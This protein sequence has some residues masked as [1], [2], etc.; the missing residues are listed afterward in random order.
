MQKLSLN[1]FLLCILFVSSS[2][3]SVTRYSHRAQLHIIHLT[4]S[5]WSDTLL[6]EHLKE[7]QQVY[8]QCGLELTMG[9][10]KKVTTETDEIYFDLEG[11]T[12]GEAPHAN[13][14]L[15]F[16]AQHAKKN[17]LSLFLFQSFDPEYGHISATAMPKVRITQPDQR[18]AENT[19]WLSYRAEQLRQPFTPGP[20]NGYSILAHE[21]GHVLLNAGHFETIGTFNLMHEV[22]SFLNGRL[23]LEQ[24]QKIQASPLVKKIVNPRK[25]ACDVSKFP[26]IGDLFFLNQAVNLSQCGLLN[27]IADYLTRSQDEISDLLPAHS[28]DTFIFSAPTELKYLDRNFFEARLPLTYDQAGQ[29]ELSTVQQKTLWLHELGHA[30]LNAQLKADWPWFNTRQQHM[31]S[32][33]R[34]ITESTRAELD[35]REAKDPK[36]ISELQKKMADLEKTVR[37]HVERLQKDPEL[38]KFDDLLAPYH[39]FFA[40][41]VVLLTTADGGAMK[42]ALSNPND[43]N[44]LTVSPEERKEFEYRDYRISRPVDTWLETEAHWVLVPTLAQWWKKTEPQLSVRSK[45]EILRELYHHVLLEV[46]ER[47]AQP[48]LH[49]LGTPEANR[50]MMRRLGL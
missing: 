5:D 41:A 20:H 8:N 31:E 2:A 35:L 12:Y 18:P 25:K 13:G 43:P 11:Y 10:T 42:V 33:G 14:A 23:T 49:Q 4:K 48:E 40:D 24:C 44:G 15:S 1:P 45:K 50:R 46:L 21:L 34:A 47:A 32:W 36:R 7:A 22:G 28:V 17:K 26:L 38:Q 6:N 39:E 29:I 19:V 16:S 27:E 37:E 30:L 9:S 3:W